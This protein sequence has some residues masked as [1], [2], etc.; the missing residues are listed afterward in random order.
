MNNKITIRIPFS[1]TTWGSCYAVV[2]LQE[3]Q[4]A[5]QY[6]TDIKSGK[7]DILLDACDEEWIVDDS[8]NQSFDTDE[9]EIY[10]E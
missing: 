5:E 7:A 1:E 3:G 2:E 10:H 8:D 9:A 4:T 6:L